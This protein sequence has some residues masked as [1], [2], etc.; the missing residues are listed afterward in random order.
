MGI[1]RP[2][3]QEFTYEIWTQFTLAV[4]CGL[5]WFAFIMPDILPQ[6]TVAAF[7]SLSIGTILFIYQNRSSL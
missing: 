2:T 6:L 4:G 3:I 7:V 1:T 5:L